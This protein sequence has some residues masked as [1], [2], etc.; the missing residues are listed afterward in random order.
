MS[1]TKVLGTESRTKDKEP[2]LA[3]RAKTAA[4][5]VIP[6]VRSAPEVARVVR[7][8]LAQKVGALLAM[9]LLRPAIVARP[10]HVFDADPALL[11]MGARRAVFR[12]QRIIPPHPEGSHPYVPQR[13]PALHLMMVKAMKKVGDSH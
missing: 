4:T 10:A 12:F 5:S 6:F 1:A 11:R 3:F 2:L 7:P 8:A 9:L 13:Q